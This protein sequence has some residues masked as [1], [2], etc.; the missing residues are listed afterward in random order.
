MS[1]AKALPAA[2]TGAVPAPPA[3]PL[4]ACSKCFSRHPFEELSQGQ[5]LCKV[6]PHTRPLEASL[7]GFFAL[8]QDCRGSFPVVKCTYCRSEFQQES[9]TSTTTFCKK[10][11][12]NV[13]KYG[14][15]TSC[16]YCSIIAAFVGGK[17]HR[18][19]DSFRKYGAPKTCEQCKQKCAFEREDKRRP[20][21]KLLCWLCSLS[22][23]RALAR[24]KQSDPA[25]HSRVFKEEKERERREKRKAEQQPRDKYFNHKIPQRPDVTKVGLDGKGPTEAKFPRL[26]GKHSSSNSSRRQH[27]RDRRDNAGLDR[28]SAGA[29]GTGDPSGNDTDHLAEITQLKEKIA[30]LNKVIGSKNLELRSK[31]A[32]ITQM[33]AKLFNEE[34]LIKEKMRKMQKV[35]DDQI[36]ML[37]KKISQ[38]ASENA[39]L[40][41]DVAKAPR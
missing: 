26:D 5:Q 2:G 21:G 36:G 30:S 15:P 20:D 18:C 9:K 1:A 4:F 13:A 10:C 19:H 17:C 37:Q 16:Q 7:H 3:L 34:N 6:R 38:L 31:Q 14:K 35:A 28:V 11:E 41:R 39:K 24:T 22:Y 29:A 8:F 27:H 33:K 25:R 12:A 32:E 40:R 23:K